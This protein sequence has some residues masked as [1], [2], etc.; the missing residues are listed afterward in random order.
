MDRGREEK[1]GRKTDIVD[2]PPNNSL[3]LTGGPLWSFET[4]TLSRV[5]GS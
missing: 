2:N 3:Q 4:S 5:A 1:A